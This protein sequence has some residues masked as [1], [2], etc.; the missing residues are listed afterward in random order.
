MSPIDCPG[1]EGFPEVWLVDFEFLAPPGERPTPVC[2][3]ALEL[4]SGR[5]ERRWTDQL[6]LP[7]PMAAGALYVAYFAPA[8]MACHLALGWPLPENLL[9]LFVQFRLLGNGRESAL[10]LAGY[11]LLGALKYFGLSHLD[12]DLKANWRAR[13]IAGPPYTSEERDGILDY[14][15]SDV[16]ALQRLLPAL[17]GVLEE[18]PHWLGHGLHFGRYMKAVARME[19]AGVPIDTAMLG[20]INANW[21]AIKLHVVATLAEL[22]PFFAGA[23]LDRRAF[24]HWLDVNLIAWPRTP[25]GRVSTSDDTFKEMVRAHPQLAPVREVMHNLAKLRLTDLAVGSDGR[26]RAMLSPL[27]SKTG[28]NQPSN[29]KFIFGPSVWIR[30]LIRP[31]RGRVLAYIDFTSQEIGIAAALSGDEALQQAYLSGDPYMA[32]A[33][34]AK[35]APPGATKATHKAL[36]DRCKAV[37]LGTLYGMQAESLAA[38]LSISPAEAHALLRAHRRAY[39]VFWAW[40]GRVTDA[41]MLRGYLDSCFG[42]R[43]HVT[44]DTRAT[45]LLNHPMQAH[46]AEILR[47]ACCLVTELGIRVCAPVHDALLIECDAGETEACIAATRAAM[48]RAS[49]IVL[50]GFEIYTDVELIEHPNRFRD[51][52]GAAMWDAIAGFLDMVDEPAHEPIELA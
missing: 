7:L 20:L 9:D 15:E 5:V 40:I 1:L 36:R 12:P 6:G 30:G 50:D 44:A 34:E 16:I 38:R 29:S 32:F 31:E 14:C 35:L 28:R 22:F 33:I 49:C 11:S 23:S 17:V 21:T 39:A 26:N 8:E 41:A 3:V 37:V 43:I 27:R 13:I 45:S 48:A 52:R 25:T 10:G 19:A 18:R 24:E 2:C 51:P 47:L 42:W 46:G 4:V